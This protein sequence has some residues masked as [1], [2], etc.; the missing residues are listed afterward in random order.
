[1][2]I[3][4]YIGVLII[5]RHKILTSDI[6]FATEY[7]VRVVKRDPFTSGIEVKSPDFLKRPL[8]QSHEG[9]YL[10]RRGISRL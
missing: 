2:Y 7:G 9:L 6:L 8:P 4:I 5:E 3:Y 1:M 10:P